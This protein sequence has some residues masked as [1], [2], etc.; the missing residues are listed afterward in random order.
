MCW[1]IQP[2]NPGRD[3][4]DISWQRKSEGMVGSEGKRGSCGCVGAR[5]SGLFPAWIPSGAFV[6]LLLGYRQPPPFP[7]T[8][9]LVEPTLVEIPL[10]KTPVEISF[11]GDHTCREKLPRENFHVRIKD[12]AVPAC[13]LIIRNR[14]WRAEDQRHS[15]QHPGAARSARSMGRRGTGRHRA[16]II[17][18]ANYWSKS[19]DNALDGPRG[20]RKSP[21]FD[22]R[23]GR[24]VSTPHHTAY[25]HRDPQNEYSGETKK[26]NREHKLVSSRSERCP[27][28]IL[29][30]RQKKR[31]E[32]HGAG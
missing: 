26:K 16:Q 13:F 7:L 9:L 12:H 30:T 28:V 29:A 20:L 2:D 8:R 22:W 25:A 6:Q 18:V 19:F 32:K 27:V 4:E 5:N 1:N 3:Q 23:T 17:W 14:T 11:T 31:G 15:C 21:G 10:E 24:R